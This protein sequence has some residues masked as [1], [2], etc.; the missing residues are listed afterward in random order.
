MCRCRRIA[1]SG[2]VASNRPRPMSAPIRIGR[3]RSR[4]THAPA[5]SPVRTPGGRRTAAIIPSWNGVAWRTRIAVN[6]I[7]VAPMSEPK[8]EIVW[9]AQ[10]SH[11]I[12]MAPEPSETSQ[13][14]M[15]REALSLIQRRAHEARQPWPTSRAQPESSFTGSA[16]LIGP[17]GRS[18]SRA[19]Y[20]TS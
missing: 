7:A 16:V 12:G 19:V 8:P 18:S 15:I 5:I 17:C 9:P 10:K 4:S 2:I 14:N 1:A 13:H 11:E 3:R 20:G 6:P